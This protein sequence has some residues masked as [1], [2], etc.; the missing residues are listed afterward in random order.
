MARCA[1]CYGVVTKDDAVCYSCGDSVPKE[2]RAGLAAK[3]AKPVSNFSNMLFLGSLGLTAVSFLSPY[4]LPLAASLAV[5]VVLFL[6][7]FLDPARKQQ[8]SGSGAGSPKQFE[9]KVE[10]HANEQPMSS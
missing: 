10:V 2:I 3:A 7:R 4:K 5:S 6:L 1:N 9:A 8:S